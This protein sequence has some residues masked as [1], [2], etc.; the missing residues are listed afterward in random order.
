MVN[1]IIVL[2]G[3]FDGKAALVALVSKEYHN[4]IKAGE[5]VNR[6]AA[7]VGGKGGG[8]ADMAQAGGTMPDK[9]DEAMAKTPVIIADMLR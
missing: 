7:I 8:R 3:E 6:V 5:L 2:G 4:R 1:G 9:L